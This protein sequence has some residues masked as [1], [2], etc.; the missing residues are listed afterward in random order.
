MIAPGGFSAVDRPASEGWQSRPP[1]RR[2]SA[3]QGKGNMNPLRWGGC[4]SLQSNAVPLEHLK[5]GLRTAVVEVRQA[6]PEEGHP[7]DRFQVD[8][9]VCQGCLLDLIPADKLSSCF[10]AFLSILRRPPCDSHQICSPL[11]STHSGYASATPSQR[12]IFSSSPLIRP[13]AFGTLV[14]S[15]SGAPAMPSRV[16]SW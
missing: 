8:P 12:P 1:G 5:P 16:A 6:D 4:F 3:T 14:R 11:T 15:P 13:W 7:N 10:A 2:G 9:S